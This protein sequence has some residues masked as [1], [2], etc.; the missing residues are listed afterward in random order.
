MQSNLFWQHI[1][2][3][4]LKIYAQH[5]ASILKEY[6]KYICIVFWNC[7]DIHNPL[8]QCMNSLSG[9]FLFT[10]HEDNIIFVTK[11]CLLD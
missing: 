4:F 2:Y 11:I 9:Q 10:I 6:A 1:N 7:M 8:F 3:K 5:S